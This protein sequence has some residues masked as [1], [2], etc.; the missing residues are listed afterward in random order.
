MRQDV[1]TTESDDE[2]PPTDSLSNYSLRQVIDALDNVWPIPF[3]AIDN[4]WYR[5]NAVYDT[6]HAAL[7]VKKT[8][9]QNCKKG[10]HVR[11]VRERGKFLV[12]CGDEKMFKVN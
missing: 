8:L 11:I 5:L 4:V 10:E 7:T 9:R 2:P 6:H 12:Y 1:G 3:R